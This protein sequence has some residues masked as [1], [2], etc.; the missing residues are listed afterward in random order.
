MDFT[1]LLGI[2]GGI[3]LV[4][5]A[6][7]PDKKGVKPVQ[8]LKDWLFAVGG[9]IMLIYS[10][11]NYIHGGSIF[12][13]FLQGLV[14]LSSI[15]MMFDT[16]DSIDTPILSIATLGL[17][18]WSLIIEP[19]LG[20]VFFILGLAGIAIGY[21]SNGGTVRRE[22]A[23]VAGSMLIALFSYIEASWIFFWLNVFFATFSLWQIT[24]MQ[25]R[26]R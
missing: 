23:L 25:K 15:F 10:T 5:G 21:A 4:C 20:T 19:N 2:L 9:L 1:T 7:C 17:I 13:V 18:V 6:A 12:F 8:S 11:L 22:I 14:N 26:H 24:R 3:V 16:D